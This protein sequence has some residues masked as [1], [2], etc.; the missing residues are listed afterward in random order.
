M[1]GGGGNDD[2]VSQEMRRQ[3]QADQQRIEEGRRELER[4]FAGLSGQQFVDNSAS[5]DDFRQNLESALA[6][7][8]DRL[9]AGWR[10]TYT[11]DTGAQVSARNV[12]AGGGG[13]R[14][15][16][17]ASTPDFERPSVPVE[18]SQPDWVRPTPAP[19]TSTGGGGSRQPTPQLSQAQIQGLRQSGLSDAE[20]E[21]LNSWYG[22][23]RD[24]MGDESMGWLMDNRANEWN[25]YSLM[26]SDDLSP[27]WEDQRN[28]YLEAAEPQLENQFAPLQR[29]VAAQLLRTGQ[30]G[31]SVG[32][33]QWGTLA[34]DYG[35]ARN[36][37]AQNA[38]GYGN[39]IRSEVDRTRNELMG[40]L[41]S[42]AST[43]LITSQANSFLTDLGS[44]QP[45]VNWGPLFQNVTAMGAAG[46]GG[47]QD[48]NTNQQINQITGGRNINV[49]DPSRSGGRVVR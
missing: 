49:R 28:L 5:R 12:T 37:M 39:Q 46:Y 9:P 23:G 18:E 44:R 22:E 17:E 31:G 15:T 41:E 7:E 6:L 26:D 16:V 30:Y 4:I 2:S 29:N 19:D 14:P 1:C 42:G 25:D 43:D 36:Q 11:T 8:G 45:E 21:Q 20:I 38:L 33:S 35:Q 32:A 47:N 24:L 3:E 40:A 13:G 10:P 34:G 27:I 48:F